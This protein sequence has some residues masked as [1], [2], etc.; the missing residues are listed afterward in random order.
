M[1]HVKQNKGR[2]PKINMYVSRETFAPTSC[3]KGRETSSG[4]TKFA[5]KHFNFVFTVKLIYSSRN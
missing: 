4:N 5:V 3:G 1:F 2:R